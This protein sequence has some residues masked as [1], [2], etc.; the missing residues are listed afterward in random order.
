MFGEENPSATA[1]ERSQRASLGDS[2]PEIHAAAIEHSR[3]KRA[4]RWLDIGCGTGAVLREIRDRYDPAHLS[5][6]DVIDWLDDDLR[7]DIEL[8]T[9]P[10]ESTLDKVGPVDRVLMIEVLEH[11]E[12]PWMVLRAAARR[13]APGGRIVLTTPNVTSL[14]H[15]LGLLVR[16]QLTS[17]KPDN[18]PHLTP[19]LPHVIE[20]VL[21]DE[22]LRV[23][24]GHVGID[25]VPLMGGRRWPPA[26]QRRTAPLTSVSLVVTADASP[27]GLP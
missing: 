20:R 5:G 10:A 17:F 26:L 14:R 25:V 23:G 7:E 19:C 8:R 13:V 15:R 27:S 16:G 21:I 2:C 1:Y 22:G 18:L 6:L 3:P 12:A 24:S 11:L 9:G 4:L